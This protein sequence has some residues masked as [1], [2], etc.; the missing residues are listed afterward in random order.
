MRGHLNLSGWDFNEQGPAPLDGEWE[1]YADTSY[2]AVTKNKPVQKDYFPL[3]SIWKGTTSKGIALRHQGRGVYRL[4]VKLGPDS[5]ADSLFL[6]G[7]LSVCNVRV[8]GQLVGSTGKVGSDQQSEQPVKHLITPVFN[9]KEE[10]ADIVMEVSN[11]HNK[12][13]GINSSILMGSHDQIESLINYRRISGA[14]I[15][16]ALLI[17]GI[18]HLVIFSM[19]RANRENLYFGG[20]CI[21]WCI[22]T[23]FNPPSAFLAEEL[24]S[25]DWSWY[26]KIC[27]LPTGLAI[28]LL[29]VFYN[30]IFPQKYGKQICWLYSSIGGIYCVY[31][32]ITPPGAYSAAAFTYFLITRTAYIYLIASFLN[33]LRKKKKGA[34]YLAP[35]YLAL[36][37]AEFD[38]ILFD[39][40]IFGSADFTP[41]GTFI[42]ILSYSLLMSARF[43]ETLSSYE[44]VSEELEVHKKKE[45]NHKMVRQHLSRKLDSLEKETIAV[46]RELI[47]VLT[48]KTE[49]KKPD[50]RELA[51]W[52]MNES[53]ECWEK[54]TGKSKADLASESGIWNI[55][56]EKDGYARTQTLDR[57][58]SIDTLP[59]RPRWKNIYATAEFVISNCSGK[60]E[61]S[62]KLEQNL[63][64]LK[65]M[66]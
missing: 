35:G 39:L 41:Y 52:L 19:R 10:Y 18:F 8:N 44:K 11:F 54:C 64:Q 37:L 6:S 23:V 55:Y 62:A 45:Q 60:T 66:S 25:I 42:F 58:M 13:G 53:L 40:N 7:A 27:L 24:L 49:E 63:N 33:D 30:S 29:L 21:V 4:K 20:F 43:A 15:G 14:I 47:H 48:R 9:S 65:K 31:T 51:V 56:I 16:G 17:M 26:I 57:Y 22:A 2:T 3:P 36:F 59:E 1:F 34:I 61:A 5:P 38:E 50:K 12:E 32:L 28:P 46:N